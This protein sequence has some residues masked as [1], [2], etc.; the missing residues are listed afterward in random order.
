MPR[1]RTWRHCPVCG[2]M[3]M[4]REDRKSCSRTCGY[5]LTGAALR[6]ENRGLVPSEYVW[7][8]RVRRARGSASSYICI[9]CSNPAEDWS[10]TDPASDDIWVRFQPRCR[11]CHRLYDGATGE[12]HPRA[13]LT[14]EKVR[15]LRAR[16]SQGLTYQQLGDEFGVS[17]VTAC[18]IVNH[19]A[20]VYV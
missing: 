15:E 7:H 10:T 12:G 5:V 1:K 9:D 18:A 13:K 2:T 11:K 17:D 6:S 19:R 16:R 8:A 20:W 4:I 3:A 14:D